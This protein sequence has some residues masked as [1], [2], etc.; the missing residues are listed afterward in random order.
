M[1]KL[2][3]LVRERRRRQENP[4]RIAAIFHTFIDP[5]TKTEATDLPRMATVIGGPTLRQEPN[6]TGEAF[7]ARVTSIARQ[8]KKQNEQVAWSA[9]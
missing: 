8:L 1:S 5:V 2:T 4:D 9:R 3:E 7:K 6:E